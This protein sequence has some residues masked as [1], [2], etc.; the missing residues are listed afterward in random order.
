[1]PKFKDEAA[2]SRK[3][4]EFYTENEYTKELAKNVTNTKG[5]FIKSSYSIIPVKNSIDLVSLSSKEKR[6]K[7]LNPN[8]KKED[9]ERLL[10]KKQTPHCNTSKSISTPK[11]KKVN[12][13]QSNIFNVPEKI[14][15]SVILKSPSSDRKVDNIFNATSKTFDGDNHSTTSEQLTNSN[16]KRSKWSTKLDWKNTNTEILFDKENK[17]LSVKG[18]Y[19]P[20]RMKTELLLGH[21]ETNNN[22]TTENYYSP[23]KERPSDE[24]KEKIEE[25]QTKLREKFG[26]NQNKIKKNI[27]QISSLHDKDF[28]SSLK[29]NNKERSVVSFEIN[30]IKDYGNFNDRDVKNIF[31]KH[32][33]HLYETNSKGTFYN[34]NQSGNFSFKIRQNADDPNFSEKMK[35]VTEKINKKGYKLKEKSTNN[36]KPLA[37]D[38]TPVMKWNSPHTSQILKNKKGLAATEESVRKTTNIL[39][40]NQY[41]YVYFILENLQIIK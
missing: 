25:M 22:I 2:Y 28:Y 32:G 38:T 39:K 15:N 10:F 27:E 14:Y 1:M 29:V 17:E 6:L 7:E 20:Q 30:N 23:K 35:I 40:S 34:G 18:E 31:L 5:A 8:L 4:K 11:E 12:H 41:I 24:K 21:L 13:L 9:L 37:Q 33:I 19:S 26:N 16:S 36:M 3:I